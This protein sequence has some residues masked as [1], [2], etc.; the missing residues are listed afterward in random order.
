MMQCAECDGSCSLVPGPTS[1]SY[2]PTRH[3]MSMYLV[4]GVVHVPSY[5]VQFVHHATRELNNLGFQLAELRESGGKNGTA[6]TDE[7]RF[8]KD[9]NG[10]GAT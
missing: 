1:Q 5:Y 9:N 4:S 8:K 3:D 10:Y 6:V 2:V 7:L